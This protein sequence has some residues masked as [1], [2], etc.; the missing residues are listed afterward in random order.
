MFF[1]PKTVTRITAVTDNKIFKM[2][3]MY[4]GYKDT[5]APVVCQ[6]LTSGI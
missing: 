2:F 1:Y 5:F 4:I 3:T 6:I